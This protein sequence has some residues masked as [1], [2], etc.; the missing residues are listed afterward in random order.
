MFWDKYQDIK[1]KTKKKENKTKQNI[2]PPS[3]H[4]HTHTNYRQT[5]KY[6]GKLPT[7]QAQ[8]VYG[9]RGQRREG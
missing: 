4:T 5:R 7:E 1:Y 3:K 8:E 9:D 2:I 6:S